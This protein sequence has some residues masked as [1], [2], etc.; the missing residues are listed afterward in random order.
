M[1]SRMSFVAGVAAV[2]VTATGLHAGEEWGTLKGQVVFQGKAPANPPANVDKDQKPCL[3]KGPIL[4]D[5]LVVNAKNNGV[6]WVLVWLTD[7]KTSANPKFVPPIHP[8]LKTPAKTVEVDQPCCAFEPRVMGLQIDQTLVVKNSATIPHNFK[9]DSIGGGPVSNPLI[10]AGG[11]AD[12]DGFKPTTVPTQYGCSIHSWMRGYVAAFPHPYFAVTDK[13]GN[14]EIKNAPAGKFRLMVWQETAGWV[15]IN[16]K[17]PRDRG[18][19]VEI[20]AGETPTDAGKIE[21]KVKD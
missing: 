19:V 1:R 8:K 4:K 14:F 11:K 13:D 17:N 10:P 15:I 5:E 20:K 3:D 2:L 12:I 9:I 16:P 7:P 6:R 21:L 18:K